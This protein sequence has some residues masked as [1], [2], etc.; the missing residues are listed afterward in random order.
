MGKV[1]IF[2]HRNPD[3]DSI[4]SSIALANLKRKLGC[5]AEART[6]GEIND[7][8]KFVLQYFHV[9]EPKYLNDVKLRIK[10]V[11]YHKDMLLNQNASIMETYNFLQEKNT[12][13]VAIVDHNNSFVGIITAKNILKSIFEER[14]YLHT[15]YLNILNTLNGKEITRFDEEIDGRIIAASYRSTTFLENIH[16][17]DQDILIVGDRHSIIEAAVLSKVKLL[18]ITGS[19]YIKEEHI[20]IAIQ[21]KVN[22]IKTPYSALKTVRNI[23]MSDYIKNIVPDEK[24]YIVLE[25]AYYDDFLADAKKLGFSNY[26]VVDKN[27]ICKGLIRLTEM[28]D[29]KRFQVILVDHNEFEQSV[30][31]LEEADILEVIDHHKIGGISTTKPINFRNMSVGSTNTIIYHLYKENN[32]TISYEMAGLML[33][34]ILSDTLALTSPTTTSIDKAVVKE[35]E[36]ITNLSYK[37]FARE[38]FANSLNLKNKSVRELLNL[39][40]KIFKSGEDIKISQINVLHAK[41]VLLKKEELLR[42]ISEMSKS[43]CMVI[44]MITDILKNG[45][46]F[47]YSDNAYERLEKICEDIPYQGIYIDKCVSRKIQV[48]PYIMD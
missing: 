26:P 8:A 35:L 42:E 11:A 46:Y 39:D 4:T 12:T 38:I 23:V 9:A 10:N 40:M 41:D 45:S 43:G 7:E 3:T 36:Q 32:I 15:S 30:I 1:Y 34:G 28:N 22:I 24:P 44:V 19:G 16:L 2:G 25:N 20:K 14:E 48:V 27:N 13:G 21:N 17:D 47:F 5:E 31:G 29:F 18:I 33:S 37:E 6:L